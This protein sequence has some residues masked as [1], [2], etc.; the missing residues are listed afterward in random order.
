METTGRDYGATQAVSRTVKDFDPDDQPRE[1]AMKYGVRSLATAD[2]FSLILRT[3]MPGIPVTEMC[4]NL[5]RACDN[6]LLLLERK[7]MEEIRAIEGIGPAKALQV[8]AVLELIRRYSTEK[9]GD[10][11]R[12][13]CADSIYELMRPEIGNLP[14]E[15]I[16]A[17]F[18][19]QRHNLLATRR[20]SQGGATS[21]VFDVKSVIK[22][23]ILTRA[24]A[25][26]LC[27]NHPSGNLLPS[28]QDDALTRKFVDACK[29]VD[30]R[31]I[32]HVIVTTDG[33]YSYAHESTL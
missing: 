14:H 5:M 27:H 32:D 18:L 21:T 23:A 25:V 28:P 20:L 3:G 13:T 29:T 19:D 33:F 2:L 1:K 17:L 8:L 24:E 26:A 7:S 15:E 11:V 16:W 31:M 12:I 6:R 10:R 30:L 22:Q 9:M 4:R